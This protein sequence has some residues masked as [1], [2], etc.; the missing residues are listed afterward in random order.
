MFIKILMLIANYSLNANT[1]MSI[2]ILFESEV[3]WFKPNWKN[4][5]SQ[6]LSGLLIFFYFLPYLALFVLYLIN[7]TL[8][9]VDAY[10]NRSSTEIMHIYINSDAIQIHVLVNPLRVN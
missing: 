3:S 9:S 2:V 5:H 7:K 8:D 6:T 4:T 10:D 1:Q